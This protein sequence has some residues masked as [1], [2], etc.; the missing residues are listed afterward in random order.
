MMND[1]K[2]LIDSMD[3]LSRWIDR[4][5]PYGWD[6]YDALYSPLNNKISSHYGK[7]L[8]IQ[9][10]K[11]SPINFRPFL[12][13][14]KGIDLK[15]VALFVQAYSNMYWLTRNDS[16]KEK[17]QKGLDFIISKSLS[18]K[19]GY[20]CWASHYYPYVTTDKNSLECNTPDIIGTC[21]SIIAL[22][23]GH[24]IIADHEYR[25]A[26]LSAS[27]FLMDILYQ[28]ND[29]FNF[30]KYSI[31]EETEEIVPN[32]SAHALEALSATLNIEDNMKVRNNCN[33]IIRSLIN[34]QNSDGSWIYSMYPDG[35]KKRIQLDFHQGYMINGL[36][37][38]L[39]FLSNPNEINKRII[40]AAEFYKNILFR[41]DGSSCYRYPL[42]FPVDIHNQAQGII[43]FSKLGR[44]NRNYLDFANM[45]SKWTIKNM[46][47]K[48]GFFNYQKWPIISNKI[49]HMRWG[50]AW[51]LLAITTMLNNVGG[52]HE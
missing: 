8:L 50:Q 42:P 2:M 10:N 12:K 9:L 49:P 3:S 39:P 44:I 19:F 34:M 24:K 37:S 46:Q 32:A 13:I 33:E 40:K 48:S 4:E 27:H 6:P 45:I 51:M 23:L 5:G 43:T 11:Y 18:Q 29:K 31:S 15:G 36:L 17:I 22:T 41:R 47:D 35:S 16:Y 21:Q 25:E 26:A 38:Y 20:D 7:V 14:E 52:C 28:Q 30:Y 1:E